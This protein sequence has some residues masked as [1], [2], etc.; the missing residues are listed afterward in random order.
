[1]SAIQDQKK[2]MGWWQYEVSTITEYNDQ[3]MNQI[4]VSE[5]CSGTFQLL[6]VVDI[7]LADKHTSDAIITL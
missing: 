3:F 5:S 2:A 7:V 4:R 1:M 6:G